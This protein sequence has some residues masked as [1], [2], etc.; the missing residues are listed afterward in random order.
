[1]HG[2]TAISVTFGLINSEADLSLPLEELLA[3]ESFLLNP[4][5]CI[6][7][8]DNEGV[9]GF[10]MQ[11]D[12][13]YIIENS[14]E[15]DGYNLRSA[16]KGNFES[17]WNR[18]MLSSIDVQE[19]EDE[20]DMPYLHFCLDEQPDLHS[21][22]GDLGAYDGWIGVHSIKS[23]FLP[24]PNDQIKQFLSFELKS[25]LSVP[26]DK[27]GQLEDFFNDTEIFVMFSSK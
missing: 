9:I 10:A 12:N 7:V 24:E 25:S 19:L 6:A 18:I 5:N 23:T 11:N 17:Q 1:M 13:N 2:L 20:A 14:D 21:E 8:M 15:M 26:M 3:G 27:F 4:V 16:L 22:L